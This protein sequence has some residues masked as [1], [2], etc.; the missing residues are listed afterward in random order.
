MGDNGQWNSNEQ[1]AKFGA[2][3]N[4]VEISQ[5]VSDDAITHVGDGGEIGFSPER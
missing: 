5:H 2:E 1:D 3:K 4:L